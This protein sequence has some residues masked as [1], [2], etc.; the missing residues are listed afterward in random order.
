MVRPYPHH[1]CAAARHE[2]HHGHVLRHAMEHVYHRRPPGNDPSTS[3]ALLLRVHRTP[4]LFLFSRGYIIFFFVFFLCFLFSRDNSL[5]VSSFP[6]IRSKINRSK[7]I[8]S[9]QS[10]PPIPRE[11]SVSLLFFILV[12]YI[13][14]MLYFLFSSSS[15]SYFTKPFYKFEDDEKTG[16]TNGNWFEMHFATSELDKTF[17]VSSN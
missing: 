2:T 9:S 17:R 11:R 13:F 8:F 3:L 14:F 15:F 7:A 6:V 12:H 4:L 10:L 1:R 5:S 16:S